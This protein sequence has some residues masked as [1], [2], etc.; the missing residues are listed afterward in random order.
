MRPT[1]YF[2][3]PVDKLNWHVMKLLWAHRVRS[4]RKPWHTPWTKQLRTEPM[5]M[6]TG[7]KFLEPVLFSPVA[8]PRLVAMSIL[9]TFF[10]LALSVSAQALAAPAPVEIAPLPVAPVNAPAVTPAPA[11]VVKAPVALPKVAAPRL[12]DQ[13]KSSARKY[14]VADPVT[15]PL[16]ATVHAR[17]A[18]VAAKTQAIQCLVVVLNSG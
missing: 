10:P 5:F 4:L 2:E 18:S 9:S 8:K 14:R 16:P 13:A 17:Y 12:C 11:P 15:T 3:G 7:R 1:S 6:K